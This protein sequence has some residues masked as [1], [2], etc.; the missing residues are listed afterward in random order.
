MLVDVGLVDPYGSVFVVALRCVLAK[1]KRSSGLQEAV[2]K[3]LEVAL[4]HSSK[5]QPHAASYFLTLSSSIISA[6]L[7]VSLRASDPFVWEMRPYHRLAVLKSSRW[8]DG[9]RVVLRTQAFGQNPYRRG[10]SHAS[11]HREDLKAS[12]EPPDAS[13]EAVTSRARRRVQ[14]FRF[15]RST[16]PTEPSDVTLD[17][18]ASNAT[19][20][21]HEARQNPLLSVFSGIQPTGI[22]HLG[23]YLGA[24]RPWK[25]LQEHASTNPDHRAINCL[26]SIVDLHALTGTQ[27][28]ALLAQHRKESFVSLLAIGLSPKS[29]TLFLQSDVPEHTTLHWLLSTVAS[30]GYLSRMTQWKS[31]LSLPES[32]TLDSISSRKDTG[33]SA[34]TAAEKLPLGLFSYPVLQAADIL[35]YQPDIVPVGEDQAQHIEFARSLARSFN[36]LY[37]AR[38][39]G[40]EDR[41]D[42]RVFRIPTLRV[43]EAKRIMSLRKPTQKMSKSDPDARNRILITDTASE[44]HAKIRGA[45]SDDIEGISYDPEARPGL[46]NLIDIFRFVERD[47]RD[48]QEVAAEFEDMSKETFKEMVIQVVVEEL[49]PVRERFQH[50]MSEQGREEVKGAYY[51]GLWT[52]R[53]KARASMKRIKD[54]VGLEEMEW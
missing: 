35:L 20:E 2:G 24:L 31:K 54:A 12:S 22:P 39:S 3:L 37:G 45:A 42:S 50:L 28:A 33:S 11:A 25:D 21:P 34:S 18:A 15:V 46:A 1:K 4:R 41:K 9:V 26:F 51:N 47:T 40:R 53:A 29:S 23:N 17:E 43:S 13:S 6:Y 16:A 44:I 52:A 14:H 36:T 30:T 7:S 32:A 38:R 49:A 8:R 5:D 48:P 27:N 10:I 19:S